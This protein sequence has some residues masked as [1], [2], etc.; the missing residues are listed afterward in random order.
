MTKLLSIFVTNSTFDAT[1]DGVTSLGCTCWSSWGKVSTLI[2][3]K[4]SVGMAVWCWNA[5]NKAGASDEPI[6]VSLSKNK[7]DC[8][9]RNCVKTN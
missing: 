3:N 1:V 5:L 4:P 6:F 8:Y 7:T 9:S 2:P